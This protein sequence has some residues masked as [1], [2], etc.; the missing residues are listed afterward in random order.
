MVGLTWTF[1]AREQFSPSGLTHPL[2]FVLQPCFAQ[3]SLTFVRYLTAS[4]RGYMQSTL[5]FD[6][7]CKP[8]LKTL[9]TI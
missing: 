3:K 8:L 6:P 5:T 7:A 2:Y 9:N 1:L 4:S